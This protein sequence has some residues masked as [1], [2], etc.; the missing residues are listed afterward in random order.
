MFLFEYDPKKSDRN[1][2]KHGI[3]FEQAKQ[4]WSSKFITLVSKNRSEERMLVI[5]LVECNC[6]TA[7]VTYRGKDKD[8]IRIISVRRSRYEEKELY[9]KYQ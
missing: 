1:K 4:I 6:W 8:I 9:K 2:I 7:I 3:D 5:G